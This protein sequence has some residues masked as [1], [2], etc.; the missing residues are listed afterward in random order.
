MSEHK[1][2]DY[3]ANRAIQTGLA[4]LAVPD[5]LPVVDELAAA[6]LIVAGITWHGYNA[7]MGHLTNA[8]NN[9]TNM[10]QSH[11]LTST[12]GHSRRGNGKKQMSSTSR[13]YSKRRN[14]YYTKR[15]QR[16]RY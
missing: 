9:S 15:R 16:K 3:A 13:S 5:P 7:V 2:A 6:G 14:Y 12:T 10:S 11:P 4:I 8:Y 1:I